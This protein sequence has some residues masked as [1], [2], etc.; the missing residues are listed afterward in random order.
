MTLSCRLILIALILLTWLP[1]AT[2]AGPEAQT[3]VNVA[4]VGNLM[5]TQAEVDRRAQK[6]LPM[7]VSFHGSLSNEK[8]TKSCIKL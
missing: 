1:M 7:Q 4:K 6:I 3:A 5:V 8:T 2:A